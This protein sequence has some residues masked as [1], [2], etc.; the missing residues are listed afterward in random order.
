MA[1][2]V[3]CCVSV[4]FEMSTAAAPA[5]YSSM[6][7]FVAFVVEPS[8]VRNSLILIGP[9]FRTFSVAVS[10][11]F[12]PVVRFVHCAVA[13]RLPLNGIGPDVILKVAFTLAPGATGPGM[14]AAFVAAP[15]TTTVH[16]GVGTAMLNSTPVA[17][18][19]MVLVNVTVV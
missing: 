8:P 12:A 19:P 10:E 9:T 2:C 1:C 5:L 6:N 13:T 17:G 7:A 14:V 16:G 18:A 11:C 4:Q 3:W 15:D